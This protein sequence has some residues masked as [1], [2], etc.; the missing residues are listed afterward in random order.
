MRASAPDLQSGALPIGR[1]TDGGRGGNRTPWGSTPR[2]S[3]PFAR[4]NGSLPGRRPWR[5]TRDE[6]RRVRES[7]PQSPIGLAMFKTAWLAMPNP[8]AE[9][10]G[11]EPP[12][13]WETRP[14]LRVPSECLAARPTFHRYTK[15][16]TQRGCKRRERE[17]NPRWRT[18]PRLSGPVPYH[19]AIPPKERP[20][21]LCWRCVATYSTSG[22]NDPPTHAATMH[23]GRAGGHDRTPCVRS[24]RLTRA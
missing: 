14:D 9:G 3:K 12:L 20:T 19:S 6:M 10:E 24:R 4:P 21:A 11:I 8:P 1:P 2:L 16:V 5:P 18:R 15:V 13:T 17:S 7:N 23:G 22:R